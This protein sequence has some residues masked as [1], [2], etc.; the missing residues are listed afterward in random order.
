MRRW[1]RRRFLGASLGSVAGALGGI[2]VAGCRSS[3]GG[4]RVVRISNWPLYIDDRTVPD[5][6]R[7]TGIT[8]QYHE[9]IND[10]NEFFAKIA[11]PL[12][13]GQSIDRDVIVLTDWVAGRMIRRGYATPLDAA[14]FPNRVNL[15]PLAQDADFDPGRRYTVPWLFGMVGLGYN[16]RVTGREITSVRDLFDPAFKGR[17][18]M[19]TEMRDTLGLVMLGEGR[20]PAKCTADD[21]RVAAARVQLARESGQIRAFTGND[22]TEDLA[23]GNIAVAIAWSGDI[24]G[25]RADNPD[26]VWVA[27]REGAILFSDNMLI[28]KSSDRVAL[29]MQWIDWCYAPAHS[30]QIVSR[31]G[32]ISAVQGAIPELARIAPQLAKSPLVNP[33]PSVLAQLR[34]FRSLS[35]AEDASF[36]RIF[37]DAIGG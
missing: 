26:L 29:A 15:T 21:I 18:T 31:A 22:Y 24:Q 34:S 7:A 20:D 3:G 37:L 9:D 1:S 25:L 32:Y 5:F 35:D 12:R 11:E 16:P 13:R 30:A 8:V 19:V 33:P 23:N 28:P 14:A 10:N 17:V 6:Q 36:T 2:G 4:S 27:P